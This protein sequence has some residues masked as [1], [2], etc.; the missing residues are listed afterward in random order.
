[1]TIADT[2]HKLPR[3]GKWGVA[4]AAGLLLYFVVIET[5]I[6]RYNTWSSQADRNE[7]IIKEFTHGGPGRESDVSAVNNGKKI[8]GEVTFPGPEADRSQALRGRVA[9]VLR[10]NGVRDYDERGREFLLSNG[11]LTSAMGTGVR[12]KRI[13]RDVS[14]ECTPDTMASILADLERSSEV[15]GVS[16]VLLRKVTGSGNRGSSSRNVGVTLSIEAW[17]IGGGA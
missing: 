5:A 16:R 14:F 9:E 4:A 3:A 11:P 15:S 8:F 10:K 6:E 7:A 17:G 13:V 2:F 1:M 12:V